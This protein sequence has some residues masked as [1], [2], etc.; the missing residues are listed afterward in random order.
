MS[1]LISSEAVKWQYLQCKE[2]SA[3]GN[4]SKSPVASEVASQFMQAVV[5]K[6]EKEKKGGASRQEFPF[7]ISDLHD[8]D[9]RRPQERHDGESRRRRKATASW[10]KEQHTRVGGGGVEGGIP[11]AVL[12]IISVVPGVGITRPTTLR[13]PPAA[14]SQLDRRRCSVWSSALIEIMH[15]KKKNL[16]GTMLHCVVCEQGEDSYYIFFFF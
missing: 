8:V 1:R 2:P 3:G 7:N 11:G 10:E 13:K 4:K 5:F 14:R 12:S 6:R 9:K 16:M 15:F